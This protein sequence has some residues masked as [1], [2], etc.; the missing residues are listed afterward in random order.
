[1]DEK[2]ESGLPL[3]GATVL[4]L[5]TACC[6]FFVAFEFEAFAGLPEEQQDA[7]LHATLN[8]TTLALVGMVNDDDEDPCFSEAFDQCLIALESY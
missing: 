7:L 8:L 3:A 6:R 2:C 1:M 4:Q 5:A